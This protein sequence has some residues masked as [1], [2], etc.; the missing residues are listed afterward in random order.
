MFELLDELLELPRHV[1]RGD[2]E[3]LFFLTALVLA[4]AGIAVGIGLHTFLNATGRRFRLR[5]LFG[6]ALQTLWLLP[7]VGIGVLLFA[8][9]HER[10]ERERPRA[11]TRDVVRF[12]DSGGTSAVDGSDDRLDWVNATDVERDEQRDRGLVTV[13]SRQF[14]TVDEAER[15]ALNTAVELLTTDLVTRDPRFREADGIPLSAVE[16]AAVRRRYVEP[17]TR[18]TD[19]A[20]FVVHRVHLQIELSDRVRRD[21]APF[22]RSEIVE[23]RLWSLGAVLGFV[24]LLFGTLCGYTRLDELSEGRFR[25]R[26]RFAAASLVTA[27]GLLAAVFV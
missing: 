24:T 7:V 10:I 26:L 9:Y 21:L 5:S 25:T 1:A 13:S 2:D 14:A 11:P 23:R 22:L 3:A 4:G 27:G 15:D 6:N 8:R 19:N 18:S 12:V 16:H 17:I 20:E